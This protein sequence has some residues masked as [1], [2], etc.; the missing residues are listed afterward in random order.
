MDDLILL[1]AGNREGMP[2][3]ADRE[4]VYARDENALYIGTP[5]G[6][7]KLTA[8]PAASQAEPNAAATLK[9]TVAAYNSLVAALKAAGI[10]SK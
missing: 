2:V 1:R 4:L 6:N 7:R 9:E 3:L 8:S 10:M 5:D